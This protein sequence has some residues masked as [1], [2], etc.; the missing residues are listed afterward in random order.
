MGD[1]RS[2]L[3]FK[4]IKA[5]VP[6]LSVLARYGIQPRRQ[7]QHQMVGPCLLPSHQSDKRETLSINP[8][9]NVWKCWSCDGKGGN[10]S[11]NVL[12]FVS[13]MEGLSVFDAAKRLDEWFP[14]N[15]NSATE[16]VVNRLSTERTAIVNK[17]LA[18][19]LK[20]VNPEHE[21]IQSRGISVETAKL[22]GV[23]FFPGAGSMKGRIV[24]QMHENGHLIGY[25]GRTILPVTDANPKWLL[26]KGLIK[27]FVYSLERCDPAKMLILCESFWGPP[28]FFEHGTQAASLMGSEMTDA[29]EAALD[30]FPVITVAFDNDAAGNEKASR[31]CERLRGKHRVLKARLVE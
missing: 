22:F 28:F 25:A 16:T 23:G 12:D 6:I 15:A 9:K 30:P 2:Q 18:F 27:S 1:R 24:F 21:M 13:A 17:P 8:E 7:N 26:G 20:D 11:G 3:D 14:A 31:I 5:R 4:A 10:G 19:Q 29:Q